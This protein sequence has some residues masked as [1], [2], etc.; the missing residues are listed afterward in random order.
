[1]ALMKILSYKTE[2]DLNISLI[3]VCICALSAIP[4]TIRRYKETLSTD[5]HR[6]DGFSFS[7]TCKR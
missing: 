2:R 7:R 5:P 1:M 6:P 3:Q 4:H